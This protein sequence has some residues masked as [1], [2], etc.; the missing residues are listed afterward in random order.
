VTTLRPEPW[1]TREPIDWVA[2]RVCKYLD[3][4]QDDQ[5]R[6][7][8]ILTGTVAGYGPDHEPLISDAEP[9]AWLSEDLIEQAHQRYHERFHAGRD[10]TKT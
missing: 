4:A 6:R 8:W 10:S 7:A 5:R 2:R 3:L 9:I 1:W